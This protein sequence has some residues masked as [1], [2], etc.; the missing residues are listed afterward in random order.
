MIDVDPEDVED[1]KALAHLPCNSE[2]I[3]QEDDPTLPHKISEI[4]AVC[5]KEKD[6][7]G[8]HCGPI[9]INGEPNSNN[10]YLVWG[11]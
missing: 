5:A 9:Y 6:H 7:T 3:L 11:V 1:S 4:V 2:C 10:C 8:Q